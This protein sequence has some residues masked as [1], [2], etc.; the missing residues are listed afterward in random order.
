[1]AVLLELHVRLTE[2]RVESFAILEENERAPRHLPAKLL[3]LWGEP[4]E[5]FLWIGNI[6]DVD[7]KLPPA[8]AKNISLELVRREALVIKLLVRT[9]EVLTLPCIAAHVILELCVNPVAWLVALACRVRL[10]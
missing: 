4:L 3:D 6:V 9:G 7:V 8:L 10:V 5:D 1:M 2:L